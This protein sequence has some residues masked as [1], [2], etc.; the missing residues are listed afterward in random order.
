MMKKLMAVLCALL[1]ACAA[2]NGFA[3][4]VIRPNTSETFRTLVGGKSFEARIAGLESVGEDEDAKFSVIITICERDRYDAAQIENL[5]VHDVLYFGD[6]S[7]I[8]VMEVI[9]DEFGITVKGG[10]GDAYNFTKG[11]D[12]CYTAATETD[13]PLWTEVLTVKVPLE[14]DICFRDWGDPENLDAPVERGFDEL[15]D[16]LQSGTD[17]APYNTR[18]TFDENGRLVEFL[19]TY[20]PWN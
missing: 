15:L 14:K 17:F 9:P 18:V 11:E 5:A 16:A 2:V 1:L 4:A 20:S 13:F 19:Y 10:F 8:A 3:D 6:G 7:G 12:G